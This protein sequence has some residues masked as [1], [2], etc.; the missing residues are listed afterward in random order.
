MRVVRLIWKKRVSKKRRA[1]VC[2]YISRHYRVRD[3]G[4]AV[5]LRAPK[6][7]TKFLWMF[8]MLKDFSDIK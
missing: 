7:C 5:V 1:T 3:D 8:M 6:D 4:V 2:K